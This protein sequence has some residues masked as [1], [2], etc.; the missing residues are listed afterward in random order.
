[1]PQHVAHMFSPTWHPCSRLLP[2]CMRCAFYFC[3][4]RPCC[5]MRVLQMTMWPS[6][7]LRW[8]KHSSGCC[9]SLLSHMLL[10]VIFCGN[11]TAGACC[12]HCGSSQASMHAAGAASMPMLRHGHMD[13]GSMQ[14]D[15]GHMDLPCNLSTTTPPYRSLGH[16]AQDAVYDQA[17]T[18]RMTSFVEAIMSR[19][20]MVRLQRLT[21]CLAGAHQI[22][23][24]L[25]A[26]AAHAWLPHHQH[27]CG[28]QAGRRP[29]PSWTSACMLLRIHT[30]APQSSYRR[31]A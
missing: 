17:D 24:G 18:A 14:L 22:T 7:W 10:H 28:Q 15:L 12:S 3:P 19:V 20:A 1:M 13:Q 29:R 26:R 21:S 4:C 2:Y 6:A 5:K 31:H 30:L 25:S 11:P 9:S 16:E 8:R 23:L 27:H